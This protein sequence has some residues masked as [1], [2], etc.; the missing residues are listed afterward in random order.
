MERH[1]FVLFS[2]CKIFKRF[3]RFSY[4]YTLLG[5]ISRVIREADSKI[6]RQEVSSCKVALGSRDTQG[7]SLFFR[8]LCI[9]LLGVWSLDQKQHTTWEHEEMQTLRSCLR[10]SGS[11]TF[12]L[13]SPP[14]ASYS[15]FN[16][17]STVHSPLD[18]GAC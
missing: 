17:R 4:T 18:T 15:Y 11:K 7:P 10:L 8:F 13:T 16:L 9:S 12:I 2:I 14:G 1:I 6:N 3:I 5:H